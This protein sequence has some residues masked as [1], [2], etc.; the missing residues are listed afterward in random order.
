MMILIQ[1]PQ[2]ERGEN[3]K[4]EI[5]KLEN[6]AWKPSEIETNKIFPTAPN[7]YVT[8]FVLIEDGKAIS[9]VAVRKSLLFHKG[10]E[11]LA[12]G[13][14]EVVTHPNYQN[15]G[16]GSQLI[17]KAADFILSQNPD[18]SIF[19]CDPIRVNFY[20]KGGWRAVEGACFVGGN[21]T[22]PFRSNNLGLTTM[23]SFLS[24]KAIFNKHDF[25]NTDIVFELGENQLW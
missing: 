6:T 15:M 18:I 13:L 24:D 16:F 25:E 10:E 19:T 9:H 8:S 14:A 2:E 21:K 5:I 12:Y 20:T 11:Y 3:I 22:T 4:N 1:Y 23:I 7:T 17:Q